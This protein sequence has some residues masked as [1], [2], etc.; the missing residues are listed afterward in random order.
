LQLSLLASAK[1]WYVDGT[2]F[3]V[4]AS[5]YKREIDNKKAWSFS[6]SHYA[7]VSC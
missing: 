1:T 5:P 4:K 6:A 7:R 3:V 2:I